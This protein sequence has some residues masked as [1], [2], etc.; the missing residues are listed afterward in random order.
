MLEF[1]L[2]FISKSENFRKALGISS[3]SPVEFTF[4]GSGEYNM[5][6]VF[7]HPE[8]GRKMVLRVPTGS[9]MHLP[10]QSRY[11]YNTL[12]LLEKSGRTPKPFYIAEGSD[13]F[14][15]GFLVM[16]YLP[17]EPLIYEKHM[18]IAAQILSDIHNTPVPEDNHLIS[19]QNPLFAILEECRNMAKTYMDYPKGSVET[20]I[21][22]K[23]LLQKGMLII[24]KGKEY[25]N[26]CIINTELNSGNFLINKEGKEHYLIDWEK[27]SFAYRGQDLGHFLAPTTTF[28]KTDTILTK[29]DI[30]AFI[31]SYCKYFENC[32][33]PENLWQSTMPYFA[34]T[35]LRGITW[36][37]M[38]WVEYQN[39][40]R[41]I[42]NE[43]TYKKIEAYLKPSFL[44]AIRNE[45]MV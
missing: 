36:C 6:Y 7:S 39:P 18:E 44:E 12:V 15:Y 11:E 24:E 13:A 43:Y 33:D 3:E 2:N 21:L 22:I 41:A 4:L 34:I 17:G 42:K 45:Y 23:E 5:N 27:P 29:K 37:A 1:D 26:R 38:A 35:C 30:M 28:W 32:K 16:D 10:N 20:K 31:E 19:P 8:N 9:Q 14:P 40:D 25:G